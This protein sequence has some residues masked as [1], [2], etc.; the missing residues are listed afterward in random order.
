MTADAPSSA[1]R[2]AINAEA[3]RTDARLLSATAA[4]ANRRLATFGR[5]FRP[6]V[7]DQLIDQAA[8]WRNVS[9]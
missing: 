3:S 2:T 9:K 1:W 6:A 8:I 7:N 5:C 4:P